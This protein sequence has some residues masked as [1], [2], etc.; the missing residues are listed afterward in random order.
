[1]LDLTRFPEAVI[2]LN[3]PRPDETTVAFAVLS[4]P[5]GEWLL[6]EVTGTAVDEEPRL[7][8]KAYAPNMVRDWSGLIANHDATLERLIQR[9]IEEPMPFN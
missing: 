6:A 3:H 2:D 5:T 7:R 9:S 1:M 4:T 8:F